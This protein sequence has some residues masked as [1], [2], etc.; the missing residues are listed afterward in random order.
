M[1]LFKLEIQITTQFYNKKKNLLSLHKILQ[2]III[3]FQTLFIGYAMYKYK[4]YNLL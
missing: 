3:N 4:N 1:F 2:L